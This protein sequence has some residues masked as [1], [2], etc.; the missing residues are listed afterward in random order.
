[1]SA[2]SSMMFGT[3]RIAGGVD[4][5]SVK[6]FWCFLGIFS[7]LKQGGLILA[8][9]SHLIGATS[10]IIGVRVS[11]SQMEVEALLPFIL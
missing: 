9:L 10:R 3:G 2:D 5:S 4:E 6:N 7:V 11:I 8:N 1:M